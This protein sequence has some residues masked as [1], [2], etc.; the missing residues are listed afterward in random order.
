VKYF[1][2]LFSTKT[3]SG[4]VYKTHFLGQHYTELDSNFMKNTSLRFSW[5]TGQDVKDV[6]HHGGWGGIEISEA[7]VYKRARFFH[8]LENCNYLPSLQRKG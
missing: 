3:D 4:I 5:N 1:N 6:L 7:E 8:K 2:K